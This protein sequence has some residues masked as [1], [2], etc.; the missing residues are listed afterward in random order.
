M[1]GNAAALW[2]RRARHVLGVIELHIKTLFEAAGK[3]L[4][5]RIIA[6]HTRVTDRTQ[7]H[8][9]GRKLRQMTSRTVF[10]AREDRLS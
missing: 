10:V 3:S 8:I 9:R 1:A 6:I 4:P 5:R 2:P 7:R